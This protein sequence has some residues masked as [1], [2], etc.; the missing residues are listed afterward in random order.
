MPQMRGGRKI[1]TEI[2]KRDAAA[3]SA[4][5]AV[6]LAK[7]CAAKRA[8]V[9]EVPTDLEPLLKKIT[10]LERKMDELNLSVK[11]LGKKVERIEKR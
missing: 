5:I 9:A 10:Q 2:S 8:S 4:A 3:L 7:P 6:Y 11:E 1:A